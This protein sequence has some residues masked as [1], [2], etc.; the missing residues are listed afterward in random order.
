M[1][2]VLG[3]RSGSMAVASE[4]SWTHGVRVL[5]VEVRSN[6]DQTYSVSRLSETVAALAVNHVDSNIR[7]G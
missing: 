1:T 7:W 5:L 3:S 2:V 6:T 4:H